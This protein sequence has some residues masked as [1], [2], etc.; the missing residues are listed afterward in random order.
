[1]ENPITSIR[2][3]Y[4]LTQKEL[5]IRAGITEQV[6]LKAEQGLYPT[7]PPSLL[8]YLSYISETPSNVV[9]GKYESWIKIEL[10]A[11]KLPSVGSHMV[12]DYVLFNEWR[13]AVCNLNHVNDNINSFCKLLKIHPYV[14]QKYSAGKMKGVPVQLIERIGQIKG[15]G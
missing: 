15:I 1:M 3:E 8:R 2:K 5:S 11:V 7:M 4:R 13:S 9:E 10:A 6:V 14:I 12:T